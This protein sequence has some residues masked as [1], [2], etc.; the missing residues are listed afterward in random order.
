MAS[1]KN[2]QCFSEARNAFNRSYTHTSFLIKGP[3]V[4]DDENGIDESNKL[5]IQL[6]H[7]ENIQNILRTFGDLM[8]AIS[9]SFYYIDETKGIEIIE[10]INRNSTELIKFEVND[11]YGKVLERLKTPFSKVYIATFSANSYRDF[12]NNVLTQKFD[13][14]FPQLQHLFVKTVNENDWKIVGNKFP[15]LKSLTV[16]LPEPIEPGRPDVDSLF[17]NSPD[18][19]SLTISYSSLK[20]LKAASDF[21]PN[22]NVLEVKRLSNDVYDDDQIHFKN[23]TVFSMTVTSE[24]EQIPQKMDFTQLQMITLS[25]SFD[26]SDEWSTFFNN[27]E[28]NTIEFLDLTADSFGEKHLSN[29]VER[30]PNIKWAFI[31]SKTKISADSIADFVEHSKRM[32]RFQLVARLI[33][34]SQRDFL[35][36]KLEDEWDIE[37]SYLNYN[38]Y[39]EVTLKR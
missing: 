13:R 22:L 30:Q 33:D 9:I 25:L 1:T 5:L 8:Q 14:I 6:K 3:F 23:V 39:L 38:D 2:A 18:I 15:H 20:I 24:N 11:C 36:G 26:F 10:C 27:H 21:L 32:F 12:N 29:I 34:I 35:E 17:K 28:E 19:N 7:F 16:D 4:S 31:H 37:M